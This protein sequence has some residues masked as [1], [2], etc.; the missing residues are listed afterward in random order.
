MLNSLVGIIASSGGAAGGTAYESIASVTATAGATTLTFSSIPSTYQSIQIRGIGLAN[1]A[2]ALS[3]A[4]RINGSTTAANYTDHVLAGNGSTAYAS[5]SVNVNGFCYLNFDSANTTAPLAS[6]IDIHNYASTTQNK[7]LRTIS[8]VDKNGS[9][10]ID[11]F[12]GLFSLTNAITSVTI[13]A[14]GGAFSAT[15]TFALYGIKGA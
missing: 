4:I 1:S 15:S 7:T 5:A 3:L 13:L 10:E 14:T 2:T 9:G 12:S 6:I 8:G 11:L